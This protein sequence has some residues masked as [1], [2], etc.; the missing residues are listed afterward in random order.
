MAQLTPELDEDRAQR[1]AVLHLD[2]VWRGRRSRARG[3]LLLVGRARELSE[4]RDARIASGSTSVAERAIVF[5][6][7]PR[8]P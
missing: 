6:A 5:W 3:D 4:R 1:S 7:P 2:G 8:M